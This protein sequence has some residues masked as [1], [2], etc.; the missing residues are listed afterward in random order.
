MAEMIGLSH[1]LRRPTSAIGGILAALKNRW[2]RRL[3]ERREP[4]LRMEEWPDYLLK[5][6]GLDRTAGQSTDPRDLPMG[7]PR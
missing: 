6:I 5:D 3:W 7:W 4:R 1:G 2:L